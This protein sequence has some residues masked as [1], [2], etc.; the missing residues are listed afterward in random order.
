MIII[1]NKQVLTQKRIQSFEQMKKISQPEDSY[2]LTAKRKEKKRKEKKRKE[3]R[4][5]F[6][7]AYF[8]IKVNP[9]LI[10]LL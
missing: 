7:S 8:N 10:G 6:L 9:F 4:F 3:K 2:K 1:G 5:V